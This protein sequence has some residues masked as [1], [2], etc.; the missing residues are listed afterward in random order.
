MISG[1]RAEDLP[2]HDWLDW[3]DTMGE[4][5]EGYCIMYDIEMMTTTEEFFD[6]WRAAAM[7]LDGQETEHPLRWLKSE[8]SPP[9]LEHLSFVLGNQ[10]FYI[11]VI[12]VDGE[13]TGPGRLNGAIWWWACLRNHFCISAQQNFD[14]HT[15]EIPCQKL[16]FGLMNK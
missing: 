8:L 14:F 9:Y 11:H 6:C 16:C 10:A 15:H 7:H 4:S 13:V 2:A 5:K 12:D 1:E 3:P